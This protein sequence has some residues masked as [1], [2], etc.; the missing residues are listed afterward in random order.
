MSENPFDLAGPIPEG[1]VVLEASAGTGK[2]FAIA[3]LFL[4]FVAD[5]GLPIERILVVTF[6]TAAAAELRDRIRTRLA[7]A[8][9]TLQLVENAVR[10]EAGPSVEA[11]PEL[12][13]VLLSWAEETARR[14][15]T[16]VASSRLR[17]ALAS[18]DQH[19]IGTIHGFCQRLLGR[20]AFESGADFEA[21]LVTDLE[22]LCRQAACDYLALRLA[23]RE[24][25]LED[26]TS[27]VLTVEHLTSL[28]RTSLAWPRA[29]VFPEPLAVS[30]S[31]DR[32][33][34]KDAHRELLSAW[35]RD[36]QA[37]RSTL[38][39]AVLG[40]ATNAASNLGKVAAW[41][42]TFR[43]VDAELSAW[44]L[45][46]RGDQ[47]DVK[48]LAQLHD[49][50]FIK[51]SKARDIWLARF[52]Q[53]FF[54]TF[55]T[56]AE[57]LAAHVD[58]LEAREL[59]CLHDF[60]VFARESIEQQKRLAKQRTFDDLLR[61]LDD[62][63]AGP[64][65]EQLADRIRTEFRA[66]LIDEFQD[67]DPVQWSIFRRVFHGTGRTLL[68]I[69][70]PKQAIYGF[71]GA[72]LA[73][74]LRAR[75]EADHCYS[76]STNHRSDAGLL[77][78]IAALYLTACAPFGPRE[79][80]DH[81]VEFVKVDAAAPASLIR[82][83]GKAPI[84]IRL[85]GVE[86][87][88]AP[89]HDVP[90]E[91]EGEAE[92]DDGASEE[93]LNAVAEDV[94]SLLRS[95]ACLVEKE[96]TRPIRPADCAVL[97]RGHA[98]ARTIQRDLRRLGVPAVIRTDKSVYQT[99]EA[100]ELELVL[101][102]AL[103]P[104]DR[105]ALASALATDI[106]GARLGEIAELETDEAELDARY[107]Q[108]RLL[109]DIL[110]ERGFASFHREMLAVF[111]VPTRLLASR[112][113]ERRVSNLQ[114]LGELLHALSEQ[115]HLGPEALVSRLEKLRTEDRSADED[116]RIRLESDADAVDVVTMHV[117]K[118]LEWG[119]VW[120]A[121]LGSEPKIRSDAAHVLRDSN[122][123]ASLHLGP[124]ARIEASPDVRDRILLGQRTEELRL[125]YVAITR[126]KHML[127]V[128]VPKKCKDDPFKQLFFEGE[129]RRIRVGDPQKIDAADALVFP[130]MR[131]AALAV[132][133][134]LPE[135]VVVS[136]PGD[137]PR[138]AA[139]ESDDRSETFSVRRFTRERPLDVHWRITSY[140]GLSAHAASDRE[141]LRYD[142]EEV[143]EAP[144][145]E[146]DTP[147]ASVAGGK[148]LGVEVHETLE[149]AEAFTA[150][151]L[152]KALDE[153]RRVPA[154]TPGETR[155]TSNGELAALLERSLA[156]PLFDDDPGLTLS[157]L[158]TGQLLREASFSL[159]VGGGRASRSDGRGLSA[160]ALA[161]VFREHDRPTM[162]GEYASRAET[163]ALSP[164]L[165]GFL[166]GAI[167]LV[168]EH[169]GRIYVADYK[170]TRL[171]ASRAAF[172]REALPAAMIEHDY[173][174]QALIYA[175]AVHRHL[176][177]R[178][179]GYDYALRFGGVLHLFLRAMD[180]STGPAFGVYFD[181][182]PR[183][184]ITAFETAL[185]LEGNAG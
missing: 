63:L 135:H 183:S 23:E 9:E 57:H 157:S 123:E 130:D 144:A 13:P 56:Y 7:R 81:V 54:R 111:G 49:N 158:P 145:V 106:V 97:V 82:I 161:A 36:R 19:R 75:S 114:Q 129:G 51:K 179:P 6:T 164:D 44:P 133:G 126:A 176:A 43:K 73:T 117:A 24:P 18:F 146:D 69:G 4:R 78:A 120:C 104:A 52:D 140:T 89:E 2:T 42:A 173:T 87:P 22:D 79:Q 105:G 184:Q 172:A 55:A 17:L 134:F 25:A 185:G 46:P 137:F 160:R 3:H 168:F 116:R 159:P 62:A 118:G 39:E 15:D 121:S 148:E 152:L 34:L 68:L 92:A 124:R 12:D 16:A 95:S 131:S 125:A 170:T 141:R 70:D 45:F 59:L 5:Q 110:R 10:A 143:I 66:A 153:C 74:Y 21:D 102:A 149:R 165:R 71:R 163:L 76:L 91:P 86:L 178:E 77:D 32:E 35:Q 47:P 40:G 80:G 181:R 41:E 154:S 175:L 14:R 142:E 11:G 171:G 127:N 27:A 119:V 33:R 8:E 108:F 138:R 58:Y 132:E 65:G 99:D 28:A 90:S 84:P 151:A 177:C 155:P 72:D 30:E 60:V 101:E 64:D 67:T 112:E 128:L 103:H 182:P 107:E 136:R 169:R 53:G 167:D 85:L 20:H 94:A 83:G 174:L 26:R 162:P 98:A 115:E 166:V 96:G 93:V 29:R 1:T 122:G 38:G 139:A 100:R 180:P 88:G 50:N 147:W 37:I 31:F 109:G 156:T 150:E 48:R 61:M 113:G